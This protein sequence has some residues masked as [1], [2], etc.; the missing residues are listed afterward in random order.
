MKNLNH[1]RYSSCVTQPLPLQWK[2]VPGT[3]LLLCTNLERRQL[4]LG[5]RMSGLWH[6]RNKKRHTVLACAS[7]SGL[8][9]PPFMIHTQSLSHSRAAC[10]S[11]DTISDFFAKLGAVCAQ[12][13]ILNKPMQIINADETSSLLEGLW[14]SLPWAVQTA[15]WGCRALS[16]SSH[17]YPA[18]PFWKGWGLPDASAIRK[19]VYRT[20][21]GLSPNPISAISTTYWA[22]LSSSSSFKTVGV[23]EWSG[24]APTLLHFSWLL[25]VDARLA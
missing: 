1:S 23:R 25:F 3:E 18:I 12:L 21:S 6:Q 13:N 17:A 15:R 7:A 20:S 8:V 19:A 11:E 4:R 10:A 9:L 14:H 5:E 2:L 22:N 16:P 24:G